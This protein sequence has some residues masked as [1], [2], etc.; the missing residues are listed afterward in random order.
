[1]TTYSIVNPEIELDPSLI[2][3]GPEEEELTPVVPDD[4]VNIINQI[5]DTIG[6][7]TLGQRY[8]EQTIGTESLK[9][10]SQEAWDMVPE[11]WQPNIQK[12][13]QG[14]GESWEDSR[15][16]EGW[17]FLDPNAYINFAATRGLE[18]IGIPFEWTAQGIS[19]V[20]GLDINIARLA[21]DFIPVGGITTALGRRIQKVTL[22]RRLKQLSTLSPDELVRVQSFA[23]KADNI[24]N[25]G[26]KG[27]V[28]D[29]NIPTIT[30]AEN[31]GLIH[32]IKNN[33]DG[34]GSGPSFGITEL[35]KTVARDYEKRVLYNMSQISPNMRGGVFDYNAFKNSPM[36]ARMSR[37]KIIEEFITPPYYKETYG[38]VRKNVMPAFKQRYSKFLKDIGLDPDIVQLHHITALADSIPLYD[39]LRFNSP[40]WWELTE[41][42]LKA[43]V[44]QGTTKYGG[45]GW[46]L[47]VVG[48]RG[49][50]RTPHGIVHLFYDDKIAKTNFWSKSEL[51]KIRNQPGYRAEK[52]ADFA[53]IVNESEDIVRQA[54]NVFEVLNPQGNF[55][56][57]DLVDFLGKLDADGLLPTKMIDG[58]YQVPQM[59]EMVEKIIAE[60]KINPL[61]QMNDQ[62]FYKWLGQF[63][64][65]ETM[66]DFRALFGAATGQ[67]KQNIK[68]NLAELMEGNLFKKIKKETK[69]SNVELFPLIKKTR[70]IEKKYK[71]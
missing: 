41:Q 38:A 45:K 37:R 57:D 60:N 47:P 48:G 44:R 15:V 35:I 21:T 64:S 29:P 19:K 20:S 55:E 61:A 34:T 46:S 67:G 12:F 68:V 51:R 69:L 30:G 22:A 26:W 36:P 31:A 11:K 14:L 66:R 3:G 25:K 4:P 18:T 24:T 58:K 54:Q 32:T 8:K 63:S 33:I 62:Q 53:K 16:I 40:E 10:L 5:K 39:G 71:K 27:L 50:Y 9:R 17:E 56:L 28:E 2:K 6:I 1:M 7:E 13:V 49:Q 59:K 43:Q 70:K 52:A 65:S 42:L 23:N